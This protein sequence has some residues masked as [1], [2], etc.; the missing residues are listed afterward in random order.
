MKLHNQ[1]TV[2]LCPNLSTPERVEAARQTVVFFEQI[3]IRI[4]MSEEDSEQL[5]HSSRYAQ[6]GVR[7]DLLVSVGGD[8]SVLH[9]AQYAVEQDLPLLGINSGRL[10]FL[11]AY[12]I[13]ELKGFGSDFLED[14]TT[15]ERSLIAVNDH[16]MTHTAL[17][18]VVI[19][20]RRLAG[21]LSASVYRQR[22]ML[23]RFRGDGLIVATP[24]GSTAYS[25]S[26]G[27]P[28]LLPDCGCFSLT[29][30]CAH[31]A[32]TS[33][34]VVPDWDEYMIT[35]SD[36]GT[37]P[38]DILADGNTIGSLT[39]SLVITKYSRALKLLCRTN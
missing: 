23:M 28:T 4:C 12:S 10:G 20:R 25:H 9:A 27:G 29:P 31:T 5:M 35:V 16:G 26:A 34:I 2:W 18:D 11:C 6:A 30:I 22:K 14:V 19:A 3:G 39:G 21:T 17:N 7:P 38:A 33:P 37:D 13:E 1:F 24:T 32:G 36:T 8:G 15:E